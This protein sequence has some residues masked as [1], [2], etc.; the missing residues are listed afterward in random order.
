MI[1]SMHELET[2]R[3][4][5][6]T[7][8][9]QVRIPTEPQDFAPGISDVFS[10]LAFSRACPLPQVHLRPQGL[11]STCGSGQARERAGAESRELSGNS[12]TTTDDIYFTVGKTTSYQGENGPTHCSA[13]SPVSLAGTPARRSIQATLQ[14]LL[15]KQPTLPLLYM[16]TVS[17]SKKAQR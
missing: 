12:T 8:L 5:L 13:S 2:L 7:A 10:G 6:E 1:T 9:V 15:A 11:H 3:A 17:I 16:D 4:L 14:F